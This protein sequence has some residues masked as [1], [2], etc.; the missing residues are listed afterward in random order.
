MDQPQQPVSEL[1]SQP[2]AAPKQPIVAPWLLVVFIIVLIAGG[3]YLGPVLI[4]F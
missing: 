1:A 2:L 3:I 4:K